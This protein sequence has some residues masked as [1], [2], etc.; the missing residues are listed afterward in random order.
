L[1]KVLGERYGDK[2]IDHKGM[3]YYFMRSGGN[4]GPRRAGKG[5]NVDE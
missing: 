2:M 1:V 3:R 5:V 4:G